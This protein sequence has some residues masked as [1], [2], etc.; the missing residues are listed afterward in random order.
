MMFSIIL[1]VLQFAPALLRWRARKLE[2]ASGGQSF[3]VSKHD[4]NR[5]TSFI[6]VLKL[7]LKR[8]FGIGFLSV[9][10]KSLL[11]SPCAVFLIYEPIVLLLSLYIAIIYATLYAFFAAF[12]IVFQETRHFSPGQGGLAFLGVRLGT[13]IGIALAPLNNKFYIS[14]MKRNGG[15]KAPPEA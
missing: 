2:K 4:L 12:P 7:N 8:P 5:S 14:A 1:L 13:L 6:Q 10:L 9:S 11:T 3:F 15:N